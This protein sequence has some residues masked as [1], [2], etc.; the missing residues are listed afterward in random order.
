MTCHFEQNGGFWQWPGKWWPSWSYI[1]FWRSVST[2]KW[3]VHSTPKVFK[4]LLTKYE[5]RVFFNDHYFARAV[6]WNIEKMCTPPVCSALDRRVQHFLGPRIRFESWNDQ[7]LYT[8]TLF[9]TFNSVYGQS[10]LRY[11]DFCE[12]TPALRVCP[13]YVRCIMHV[14]I[15]H[16]GRCMYRPPKYDKKMSLHLK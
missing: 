8:S 11:F 16:I 5:D 2:Q 6:D 10:L 4:V 9:A 1:V 15:L 7:V 3:W 13:A 14:I 12:V